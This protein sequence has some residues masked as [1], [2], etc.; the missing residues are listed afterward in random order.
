MHC[1]DEQLVAYLDGELWL[2][3]RKQVQRHLNSCWSCRT[4]LADCEREIHSLTRDIEEWPYPGRQWAADAK[5][6]LAAGMRRVES[7]LPPANPSIW[8]AAFPRPWWSAAA[9]AITIVAAGTMWFQRRPVTIEPAPAAAVTRVAAVENTV[10][11][12]GVQQTFAVEL[13]ELRPARRTQRR[14]L[15]IWSD[16]DTGRFASR[17]TGSSGDLKHALWRPKDG[18]EMVYN[19]ASRSAMRRSAARS[20]SSSF[21]SLAAGELSAAEIESSFLRWLESRSWRPLSFASDFLVLSGQDG[22]EMRAER[23]VRSD[24]SASV[25]ITARKATRRVVAMLTLDVDALT[26]RPRLETIRFETPEQAVE[27]RLTATSITP[28]P[29]RDLPSEV[30]TGP[31]S[32]APVLTAAAENSAPVP[33]NPEIAPSTTPGPDI[34]AVEARFVLHRAG[35]CLGEPVEITEVDGRVRIRHRGGGEDALA[36]VTSLTDVLGALSDLR[37][38]AAGAPADA[39]Q[40]ARLDRSSSML[41]H[42]IA[43]RSLADRFAHAQTGDLGR[44]ALT[45]LSTMVAEHAA[46]ITTEI[47]RFESYKPASA[48]ASPRDWRESAVTIHDK[49]RLLDEL[50]RDDQSAEATPLLGEIATELVSLRSSL[51]AAR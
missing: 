19:S 49:I 48:P 3:A 44:E 30:F 8:R 17:W 1:S 40:F 39:P 7:T 37:R 41:Q 24:G 33:E 50:I 13:S 10:N 27:L 31:V 32:E 35:A 11:S 9:F 4:R 34:R 47:A 22:V 25:R 12:H 20:D 46:A 28:L 15:Q 21:D 36:T 14:N 42:A 29:S 5:S 38:S 51:S 16:A 23:A 43:L 18:V 6:Q 45:W 2:L 26:F